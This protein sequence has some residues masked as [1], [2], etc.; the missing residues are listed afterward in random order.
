MLARHYLKKMFKPVIAALAAAPLFAGAA[1]AGPYVNVE[2]NASYPDGE[3]TTATT[4]LHFGF[5]GA[6]EDG[7]VAYYIQ[8]GPAFKHTESSDDTETELSGKVGASFQVA[9]AAS[10]YGEISGITNED[11]S[12]DDIIDFGG[13]LGVKYT[14]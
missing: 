1:F 13:K 6:S 11:S 14:F 9:D 2:A 10:I 12:G 5:D 4:D 7:K 3:Y 8:G